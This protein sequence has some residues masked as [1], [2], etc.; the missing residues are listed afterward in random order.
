[1]TP[2]AIRRNKRQA[3]GLCRDC[4][5]DTPPEPGRVL[6]KRHLEINSR[7]RSELFARRKAQGVCQRPSCGKPSE[8]GHVFCAKHHR[9]ELA[10]TKLMKRKYRARDKANKATS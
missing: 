9:E 3:A 8:G 10:Y 7:R 6:C 2:E 4:S 5:D 1:M